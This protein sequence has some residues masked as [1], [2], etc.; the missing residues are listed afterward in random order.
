MTASRAA[1]TAGR[2][3][4]SRTKNVSFTTSPKPAPAAAR[5]PAQVLEHLPRLRRRIARPDQFAVLV[6]RDLAAH[7]HQPTPAGDHLTVA[8]PSGYTLESYHVLQHG[9]QRLSLSGALRRRTSPSDQ[10]PPPRRRN[11]VA[12]MPIRLSLR[13]RARHSTMSL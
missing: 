7:H 6:L 4:T 13:V 9:H 12:R 5:H 3:A 2:S 1:R 8:A 11:Q 10:E